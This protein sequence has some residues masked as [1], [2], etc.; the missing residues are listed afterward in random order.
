ML[1]MTNILNKL[2][3]KKITINIINL[4]YIFMDNS[5]LI[6]G[7]VRKVRDRKKQILTVI[8]KVLAESRK[9]I[10]SP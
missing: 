4:K 9:C 2:Y 10:L 1:R 6:D 5:L 8:R 7:I 3:G